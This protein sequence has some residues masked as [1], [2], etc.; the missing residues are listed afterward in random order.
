MNRWIWLFPGKKLLEVSIKQQ[1]DARAH[2]VVTGE[3]YELFRVIF[4]SLQYP[5]QNNKDISVLLSSSLLQKTIYL[6]FNHHCYHY[7]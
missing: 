5:T 3:T 2:D 4:C 7:S 1:T 6:P